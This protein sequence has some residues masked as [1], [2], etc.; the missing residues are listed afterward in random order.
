PD[1][2]PTLLSRSF[3]FLDEGVPCTRLQT[4][5]NRGSHQSLIGRGTSDPFEMR[6]IVPSIP[7]NPD[8]TWDIQIIIQNNTIGT[9]PFVFDNQARIGIGS[10][11][12]SS[13]IGLVFSANVAYQPIPP[14]SNAGTTT[15]SENSIRLLGPRQRCA[16]R[17]QIPRNSITVPTGATV[18]SYYRINTSG[19]I[20]GV[21]IFPDQGLA[22]VAG[23]IVQSEAETIILTVS[24]N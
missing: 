21:T 4:A 19:Q 10:V 8:A 5:E 6:V 17:V 24:A 22:R 16:F 9:V 23:G 20:T 11:P 2:L 3:P 12:D 15:F 14:P 13:G 18:R 7:E 1:I